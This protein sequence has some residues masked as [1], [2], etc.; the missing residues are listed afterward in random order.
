M[1]DCDIVRLVYV[2]II[3]SISN[4]SLVGNR[5]GAK[6]GVALGDALAVNK[7]LLTIRYCELSHL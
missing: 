5:I 2:C 4:C 6:G 1:Y 3:I 7:T